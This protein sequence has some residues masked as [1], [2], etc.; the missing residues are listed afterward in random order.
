MAVTGS[1]PP[2]AKEEEDRRKRLKAIEMYQALRGGR[3][4]TNSE[5]DRFL[6]ELT[7]SSAIERR[8]RQLSS[9]GQKLV[10]SFRRYVIAACKMGWVNIVSI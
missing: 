4:P 1:R 8:K 5:I 10:D 9:D 6:F 7:R 2:S 3:L